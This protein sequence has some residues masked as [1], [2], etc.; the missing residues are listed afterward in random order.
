MAKERTHSACLYRCRMS[1]LQR[2]VNLQGILNE[3]RARL[4]QSILTPM[5]LSPVG[6]SLRIETTVA[7]GKEVAEHLTL[8]P[9]L[10]HMRWC[11]RT[12]RA[13]FS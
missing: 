3:Q 6:V 11:F 10:K 5:L 2:R 12:G 4:L 8:K 1:S 7:N 9:G 13:R